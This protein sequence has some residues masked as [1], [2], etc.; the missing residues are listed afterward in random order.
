VKENMKTLFWIG[1]IVLALGLVSLV[2]PLP[3][4]DREG[5]SLGSVSVGV[6]TRSSRPASPIVGAAMIL[7]G[8]GLMVA[9]RSKR[10]S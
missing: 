7:G 2:V 4:N 6:E 8:A 3:H 10:F 1:L 5:L 9:G